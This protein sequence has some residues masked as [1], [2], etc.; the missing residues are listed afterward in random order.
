MNSLHILNAK[1]VK[2]GTLRESVH[3]QNRVQ[4]MDNVKK[5][6]GELREELVSSLTISN[7]D[8]EIKRLQGAKIG[9]ASCRER[10]CPYV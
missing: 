5:I 8:N 9:R 4:C 7:T 6:I 1:V 3:L 2:D 10:V